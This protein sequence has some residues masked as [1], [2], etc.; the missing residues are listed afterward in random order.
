MGLPDFMIIIF[1]NVLPLFMM[2]VSTIIV[3][4]IMMRAM[5]ANV[6]DVLPVVGKGF[7]LRAPFPR[8]V[9]QQ[10]YQPPRDQGRVRCRIPCVAVR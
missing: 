10:F 4:V 2:I 7:A 3:L 1:I 9:G 5:T 8:S 6:R